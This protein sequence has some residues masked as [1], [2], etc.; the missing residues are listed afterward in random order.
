MTEHIEPNPYPRRK[1]V[2]YGA[3]PVAILFWAAVF[4]FAPR[5]G[6][7]GRPRDPCTSN[8]KQISL[9]CALYSGDN[10]QAFPADLGV[11]YP[12]YVQDA[13]LFIC[14]KTRAPVEVCRSPSPSVIAD[15]NLSVCYV[16]GIT[17]MDDPDYII[18]FSEEWNHEGTG[19]IFACIS[20]RVA[21]QK[22]IVEFHMWLAK[23]KAELKAKGRTMKVL[24]P[25]WSTWP[26]KP[27][28]PVKRSY[29]WW[30]V[31]GSCTSALLLIIA[32]TVGVI[33]KYRATSG[34]N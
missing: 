11:L 28:W 2:E 24:R 29:F 1:W 32:V 26:A 4:F 6:E 16:S 10:H 27:N 5:S 12:D 34:R 23:Q 7:S 19:L 20:G 33:R 3:L 8:L 17:A 13:S 14:R 18:A 30:I 15:K 31:G 9:A 22:D 25:A 21:W